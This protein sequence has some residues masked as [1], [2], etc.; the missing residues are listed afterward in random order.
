MIPRSVSRLRRH[1]T[2]ELMD[3]TAAKV[4]L[5]SKY[6][7]QWKNPLGQGTFGAVYLGVNRTTG[8]KVAVKKISKRFTDNV[9]F[10]REMDA[11][12]HI[13]EA[14][15]HPN[16]CGLRE[17]YDEG[18]YYYLVLDLVSGGE[19]F[20]HLCAQGAYSEAD[21][22]RLIR[23]V[24][25]SLAFLHGIGVIHGDMKPEN[26]MLSSENCSDAVIKVVDFGCAHVFAEESPFKSA[27][28]QQM[29]TANTPAYSPP[30]VLDKKSKMQRLEASFDMWALGVILYIM[31]TG[32]HPFDLYGNATDAEIEHQILAGKKPPLD[33]SPLTAH[34][35]KDAIDL[36]NKLLQWDPK[37]RFTAHDLLE[38][39]WVRGETARTNKIADSDK[40][41]STY[42]AF[43]TKLEAK[44]FAD[45]V[46]LSSDNDSLDPGD[47][48]K[49]TSLI[50]RSFHLLDPQH[51]GYVTTKDLQRLTKQKG[52]AAD[53]D[54]Q[55]S[56]SGF[57]DLL[58]QNMKNRYFP[59]GH[60]VY[61]EGDVGNVMYFLN[62][63]TIEVYTRDGFTKNLRKS[64]DFFGEG[65]LLHPKKIRSASI[66]CVTPVHAIEVSREYFEKYLASEEGAKLSLREKDKAR[67]RQRAKT[68]LQLQKSMK[69]TVLNKGDFIF[70]VGEEGKDMYIL[71]EGK[72]NISVQG[73][74]VLS[75]QPGEMCGEHSLIFGRPR[76]V[77]AQC[78]S[79]LCKLHV[80]RARDF[81]GLLDLH[82][83]LKESVRD[84]CLR[85]DFQKA[86]C[87]KIKK[88]FPK[89]EADLR[90][91]FN[92]MDRNDSGAIELRELRTMIKQFDPTYT[93]ADIRDILKSLDLND[94]GSLTWA[95]FIRI[96]GMDK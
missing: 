3:S 52:D 33:K 56:L 32:V 71:E 9:S 14:G 47:V 44:V 25:S 79:D 48:A 61:H 58:A 2:I 68:I 60:V 92:S 64:G 57:S 45:M 65:A 19:M 26:L 34:L 95:E 78:V 50:E 10:Q 86:L 93:E 80:L 6:Q 15:G 28:P 67:K 81:Y 39:P 59:K 23:E 83:S 35:S 49:R 11:L 22:A 43:K 51:R 46:S 72:V 37:K 36:I 87:F 31:L 40:R 63:G 69:D 1:N 94:S 90:A 76:N 4:S 38:N 41:L 53:D 42:K 54:Q 66:R 24:S 74:N 88:S 21:A 29:G 85:R 75:L 27:A 16:I 55:L 20:D 18:N 70:Q 62:S 30:E 82:P 8:Q 12:L 77:S 13:R 7:V 84:I 17:N 5:E 89:K 73:H 91:A 96:F